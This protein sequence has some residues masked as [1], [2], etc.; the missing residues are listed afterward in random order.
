MPG[1]HKHIQIS[2]SFKVSL[3]K[4]WPIFIQKGT[5]RLYLGLPRHHL[6]APFRSSEFL[7]A[8]DVSEAPQENEF[9]LETTGWTWLNHSK[10][11]RIFRWL[12]GYYSNVRISG[13]CIYFQGKLRLGQHIQGGLG[14]F[15]LP[16][17]GPLD[18]SSSEGPD[19]RSPRG[20][21]MV[22]GSSEWVE[23]LPQAKVA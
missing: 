13:C 17:G 22:L 15:C 7:N 11:A 18:G 10:N 19:W 3:S 4:Y 23:T 5:N 6:D 21:A 16:A 14:S 1:C 20:L 12:R 9:P 8:L 2:S